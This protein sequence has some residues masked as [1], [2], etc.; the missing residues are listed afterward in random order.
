MTQA[1][2]NATMMHSPITRM[3]PSVRLVAP[4]LLPAL[5]PAVAR[6][7][8]SSR[9]KG[10]SAQARLYRLL[11][12]RHWEMMVPTFDSLLNLFEGALRRPFAAGTGPSLTRDE[13]MLVALMDDS[14]EV[15]SCVDCAEGPASALESAV[16][17]TRV[18]MK[19]VMSAPVGAQG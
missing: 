5:I 15:G 13:A 3:P 17:S 4:I 14:R 12:I 19:V 11:A 8:R 9:D 1:E 16:R 18:M 6:R 7:W 10:L 2:E